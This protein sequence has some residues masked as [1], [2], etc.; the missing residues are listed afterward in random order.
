MGIQA[1]KYADGISKLVSIARDA[2]ARLGSSA[3]T[4]G[5]VAADGA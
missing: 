2:A 3:P 4:D 1:T 5:R